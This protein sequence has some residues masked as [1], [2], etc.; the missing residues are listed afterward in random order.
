VSEPRDLE[1]DE[2]FDDPELRQ[3]A[4][5]L[6]AAQTPEPPFDPAFRMTLRRELMQQ[7]W[8]M[9]EAK[10]PWWRTLVAPPAMAWAGAA[11]AAVVVALA[12]TLFYTGPVTPTTPPSA[13]SPL[14]NA[15]NV[16]VVQPIPVAFNQAMDHQSVEQAVTIEPATQVTFAWQGNTLLVQ[17]AS[18]NLAPNTQYVVHVGSGARTADARPIE[19]PQTISFVT[20]TPP[21]P[22]PS[23]VPTPAVSPPPPAIVAGSLATLT[24]AP[25]WSAWSPDGSTVFA[26][27]GGQ[28]VAVAT[29]SQKT[30][31][32]VPDGVKVAALAPDGGHVAYVRNGH[33]ATVASDGS[34]QTDVA[35]ADALAVGW[36]Q[37]GLV[38]VTGKDVSTPRTKLASLPEAPTAA[39][40]SP[41]GARLLYAAAGAI[42]VL[43]LHNGQDAAAKASGPPI[44]WAPDG[45]RAVWSAGGALLAGDPASGNPTTL[46]TLANVSIPA[47]AAVSVTW[48]TGDDILIAGGAGIWTVR[49]DGSSLRRLMDGDY[50]LV[51]WAP[52]AR[53]ISFTRGT[54]LWSGQ[55]NG[56]SPPVQVAPCESAN[57]VLDEFMAARARG[58]ADAAQALLDDNGRKAYADAN[59]P[60]VW[61]GEPRLHRYYTVLAQPAGSG[62][63]YVVRLVLSQGKLDVNDFDEVLSFQPDSQGKQRVHD[64]SA[65]PARQPGKGPEVVLVELVDATHVRVSF[66]SDLDPAVAGAVEVRGPGGPVK[67][68]GAYSDRVVTLTL[69]AP[70]DPSATYHLVV[71]AR[72]VRDVG[73]RPPQVDYTLD[74]SGP[75]SAS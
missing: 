12:A 52:D 37:S 64:S 71:P 16:A 68:Q 74:F 45:R 7:A 66:D 23:P 26:L 34:G 40:F 39:W 61:K 24:A 69:A 75:P 32:L 1:L 53:H 27:A 54:A 43:D 19:K 47:D 9:N 6:K 11:A 51:N 8:A 60:L 73:G 15:T 70:L 2:L 59:P 56:S 41:A 50:S 22:R 55:V 20:Q 4:Y 17:P 57:G 42:H 48:S 33:V 44:A 14:D 28:L 58:D 46:A 29:A 3:T 31:V 63:R 30:S 35:A 25:T 62:C 72:S 36:Q 67:M 13:N 65:T 21:T 49:P 10:R 38:Y 5:F 18:G